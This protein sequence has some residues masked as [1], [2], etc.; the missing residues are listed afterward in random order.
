MFARKFCPS[1]ILN[2]CFFHILTFLELGLVHT[3]GVFCTGLQGLFSC[4]GLACAHGDLVCSVHV[5]FLVWMS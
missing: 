1:E 4:G 2:A 5:S 3:S